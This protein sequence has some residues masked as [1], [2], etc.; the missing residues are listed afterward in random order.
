MAEY[1]Q[2]NQSLIGKGIYY[3]EV[4][5]NQLI[6]KASKPPLHIKEDDWNGD[7]ALLYIILP[8]FH[9]S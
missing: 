5:E 4:Q 7:N 1:K 3:K 9:L 6:R 2:A 8:A